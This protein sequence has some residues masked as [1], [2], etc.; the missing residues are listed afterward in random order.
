MEDEEDLQ[1]VGDSK[2]E[3]KDR[4]QKEEVGQQA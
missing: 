2:L 3:R 1:E 4:F